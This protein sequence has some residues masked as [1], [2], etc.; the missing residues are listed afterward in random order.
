MSSTSS[1]SH[2][3]GF[4][5]FGISWEAV[6]HLFGT[7]IWQVILVEKL[8]FVFVANNG[9]LKALIHAL[10]K[11]DTVQGYLADQK[12]LVAQASPTCI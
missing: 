11:C 1:I 2:Y 8:K 12:Y 5:F 4:L 6:L 7:V 10:L 9:L 3:W